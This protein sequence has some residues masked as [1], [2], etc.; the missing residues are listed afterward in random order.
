MFGKISYTF[1]LMSASWQ[2]LKKDKELLVF[3]LL[4]GICCLLVIAS[5][6]VPV[7][8]T[9]SY[10]PPAGE[11][12]TAQQVAYYLT[13]FAFYFCNYFV[14]IFFNAAVISC[15]VIRLAGGDPTVSDG[16]RAAFS[17]IH[18]IAAW[19]LVSAT[20]GVVLRILED[21]SRTV[22]R[23]VIS[24]LGAAWAVVTYLA[25]PVLVVEQ[26]GPLT[27]FKRSARLLKDTWGEQLV[28]GFSFGLVFFVLSLPALVLV[29]LGVLG[30]SGVSLGVGI[31]LAVLYLLLLGLVQSALQGIFQAALY[32]YAL[33]D[34]APSEFGGGLLDGAI[35]S[36]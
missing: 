33:H 32:Y 18:L 4:S 30:G 35:R 7:F 25:V 31:G 3:P 6:A 20:V 19:A 2:V 15:A 5:F 27:A 14:I 11:A 21:R 12:T 10:A 28:G 24:L 36:R 8:M 1:S 26:A 13:L 29:V 34:E 23:I 22:G 9:G 17:R 16:L